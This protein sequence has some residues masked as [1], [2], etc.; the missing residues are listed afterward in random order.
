MWG[1][2]IELS[3]LSE[4]YATEICAIDIKTLHMYSYGEDKGYSKRVFVLYD[5]IHYDALALSPSEGAAESLDQTIFDV[6]DPFV[7]AKAL[8]VTH[9]LQAAHQFTDV[10]QF[11]LRCSICNVGLV[12][13]VEAQQHAQETGHR[14]FAEY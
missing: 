13:Q 8:E 5:G 9:Q 10:L 1:G 4:Y 6:E 3:I 12:G 14:E 2:A 11:N 7:V